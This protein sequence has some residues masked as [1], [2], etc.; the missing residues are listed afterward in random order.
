MEAGLRII[1]KADGFPI[2]R[3]F[4][5]AGERIDRKQGYEKND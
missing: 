3:I 4:E 1:G 2:T 5:I